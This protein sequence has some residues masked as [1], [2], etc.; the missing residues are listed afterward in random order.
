MEIWKTCGGNLQ[1][2]FTCSGELTVK[3]KLKLLHAAMADYDSQAPFRCW[4]WIAGFVRFKLTVGL[5]SQWLT[6]LN[7]LGLHI[8]IGK[9][10]V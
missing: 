7:F 2:E 5:L 8:Y 1:F 10:T 6:G 9:K 3:E 4:Y